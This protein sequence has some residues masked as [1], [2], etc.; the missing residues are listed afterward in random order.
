MHPSS[1]IQEAPAA[2]MGPE[3]PGENLQ[4]GALRQKGVQ[5]GLPPSTSGVNSRGFFGLNHK[6]V[7][8]AP[9]RRLKDQAGKSA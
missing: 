3:I 7:E 4:L 2:P 1:S 8:C 9:E 6:Q 5:E